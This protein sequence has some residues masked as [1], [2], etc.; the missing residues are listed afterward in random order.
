MQKD[1]LKETSGLSDLS[2]SAELVK[3]LQLIFAIYAKD[4]KK[5]REGKGAV[6]LLHDEQTFDIVVKLLSVLDKVKKL[7][8]V[9]GEES[10][11]KKKPATVKNIQ[12][13]TLNKNK[14]NP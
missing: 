7:D 13:F 1:E 6:E 12:D 8:G 3:E 14:L 4:L 5:V 9:D 11:G 2:G 10:D